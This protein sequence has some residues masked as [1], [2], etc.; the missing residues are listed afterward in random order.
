MSPRPV[1]VSIARAPDDVVVHLRG[2]RDHADGH[3][4]EPLERA[5]D[6]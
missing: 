5:Q 4:A 1:G 2:A 3:Y 6:L